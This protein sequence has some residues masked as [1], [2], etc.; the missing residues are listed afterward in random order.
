MPLNV[1]PIYITDCMTKYN[2]AK[3][4]GYTAYYTDK[5]KD[6]TDSFERRKI[7][8]YINCYPE[9]VIPELL[10]YTYV[11]ICDSNVVEL[12]SNYKEFI[13]LKSDNKCLYLTSGW[14]KK[15]D[16]T[17]KKELERSLH[18]PRWQY[19]FD[20]MK[21]SVN[22]YF[23]LLEKLNINI[24][25]TPVV[26]AK[27]IGWNI[28]HNYKNILSDFVYK[29]YMKHLQGNIIFLLYLKYIQN[30]LNIIQTLTMMVLLVHI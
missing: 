24:D 20:Q 25:D 11:F 13:N 28:K 8:A 2:Q 26:S 22:E 16:N 17:M 21:D 9:K 12:D 10:Q 23:K 1:T 5:Y 19:N 29:E 3:D 7:I 15:S 6:I 18:N 27:Y 30:I 4:M 14:Y